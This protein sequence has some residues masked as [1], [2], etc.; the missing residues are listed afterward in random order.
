MSEKPLISIVSPVYKAAAI[1]EELVASINK[2]VQRVT[3]AFEIILVEDGSPDDSWIKIAEA[4]QTFA[5]VRGIKLS[6]NFGQHAAITAGL[7]AARGEWMVVMDCDLQDY[8]AEIERLYQKAQEGFEVV[9]AQRIERQD[10]FLKRLSS[11]L[12]YKVFS[13]MTETEQDNSIANFGIYHKKVIQSILKMEDYNRYLPTMCRWVGFRQTTLP[14]EHHARYVGPSSYTLKQLLRLAMNNIL[15]FSEKPLWLMVKF[16][17]WVMSI[18]ILIA[19]Y[20]LIKYILGYIT[21][22]GYTSL[23]LS[24]WLGIG[25]LSF[26]LGIVGIYIG[27]VYETVKRRPIYLIDL[28]LNKPSE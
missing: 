17:M 21:E 26:M 23:I 16:G 7:A 25:M 6:R 12:F 20:N 24:I 3:P 22:P 2:Y 15:S 18:S 13:Y 11:K 19:I 28:D 8:P 27:K 10:H 9:Y 5:H 14:V 4:C 1:V